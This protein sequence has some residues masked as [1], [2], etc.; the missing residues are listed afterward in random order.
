[1]KLVVEEPNFLGG[2]LTGRHGAPG[3]ASLVGFIGS[4]H[5]EPPSNTAEAF[6][7]MD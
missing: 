6:S 1:M 7:S 2:Q 4:S 3:F 5:Q